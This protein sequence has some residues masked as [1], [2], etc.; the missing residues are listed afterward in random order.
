MAV[1]TTLHIGRPCM[2][3]TRPRPRALGGGGGGRTAVQGG[4]TPTGARG[5]GGHVR[6]C[7]AVLLHVRPVAPL[8]AALH[9]ACRA[10]PHRGAHRMRCAA[11]HYSVHCA[12]PCVPCHT[13]LCV[14][15]R[16]A[17]CCPPPLCLVH[18]STGWRV[19]WVWCLRSQPPQPTSAPSPLEGRWVCCTSCT[20]AAAHVPQP[21]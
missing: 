10:A 17:L 19:R 4:V 16:T 13:A 18:V 20:P 7:Y 1:P 12:A 6:V 2:Q 8:C 11:R 21:L 9:N 3:C 14:Q 15:C 5:G